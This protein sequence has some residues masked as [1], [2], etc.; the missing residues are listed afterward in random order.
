MEGFLIVLVV[1]I[2]VFACVVCA[3]DPGWG[4]KAPAPTATDWPEPSVPVVETT[5]PAPTTTPLP[6]LIGRPTRTSTPLPTLT[7]TPLPVPTATDT[8]IPSSTPTDMPT[9][10]VTPNA[11]ATEYFARLAV[12][13]RAQREEERARRDAEAFFWIGYTIQRTA[14]VVLG[15]AFVAAF[16]WGWSHLKRS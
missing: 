9:I 15:A 3:N 14:P 13:V 7:G 1:I 11:T 10:T 6:I 5:A 16:A 12:T 4:V 2:L 8:P